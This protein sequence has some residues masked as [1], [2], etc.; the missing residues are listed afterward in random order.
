VFLA[1]MIDQKWDKLEEA[2]TPARKQ[3]LQSQ[4]NSLTLRF[5]IEYHEL[6]D[7]SGM[8]SAGGGA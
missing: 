2:M 1:E 5:Q 3:H 8:S 7:T 4:K 6:L